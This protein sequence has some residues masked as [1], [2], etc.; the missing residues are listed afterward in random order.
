LD[1]RGGDQGDYLF[2]NSYG[3]QFKSRTLQDRIL[4]FCE[5]RGVDTKRCSPHTFRHTFAKQ[6]VLNG[7]DL[8][9]LQ[10]I[11]GHSTLDM[12]RRYVNLLTDDEKK[13]FIS[14]LDTLS[15]LAKHTGRQ[16]ISMKKDK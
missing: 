3:D 16:G 15:K 4:L 7:M 5:K 8:F 13:R 10:K 11:L 14:P 1:I 12:V 6:A 9:T 2:C